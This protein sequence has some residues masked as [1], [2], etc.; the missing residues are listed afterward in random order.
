MRTLIQHARG[1]TPR[2]AHRDLDGML[3]D[4]LT[5]DGFDGRSAA[6][7]RANDPTKFRATGRFRSTLVHGTKLPTGDCDDPAGLPQRLFYND[8]CTIWCSRR[9][10]SMPFYRR[11]VDGDECW[12][13]HRGTGCVETEFGPLAFEI[14][15]A[16]V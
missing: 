4:E 10:R 3:E 11:N 5:R 7:Y 16:H 8:D 6:L 9:G 13:V 2:Q 15:R 14:G 1:R 12:F